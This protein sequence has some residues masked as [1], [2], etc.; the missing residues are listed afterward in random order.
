MKGRTVRRRLTIIVLC[1]TLAPAAWA[2]GQVSAAASPAADRAAV[3]A[4]PPAAGPGEQVLYG[5]VRSL[6][7]VGGHFEMRFDPALWLTGVAAERAAREDGAIGPGEPVPND[8]Y[9]VDGSH[10]LLTYAVA[11]TARA[12]VLTRGVRSTPI[13]VPEL[14]QIVAGRNPEHRRLLE[15]K[16]G[17]WLRV[18][19]RYPNPVVALDQQYQ[20]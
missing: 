1:A 16:A 6:R 14:S 17:F 12:T 20:P 15:P 11:R 2:S 4:L 9:I 10:R 7:R 5:H 3:T 19:A 18:G 13:T 8:Y